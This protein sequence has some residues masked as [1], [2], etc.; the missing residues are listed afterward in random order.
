MSSRSAWSC[1]LSVVR[2]LSASGRTVRNTGPRPGSWTTTT[3]FLALGVSNTMPSTLRPS[4]VT[5]TS[6]PKAVD[7]IPASLLAR[8]A[9]PPTR[10][11][12]Q[13]GLQVG[14]HGEDATVVVVP[15]RQAELVEDRAHVLLDRGVRDGQALADR[16]VR[17]ALGD[18]RQHF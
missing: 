9:A 7:S 3:T 10:A 1:G 14:Q 5:V 15:G 4:L 11:G 16:L 2:S 12:S 13:I 6:S 17:A 18:Q 8:T